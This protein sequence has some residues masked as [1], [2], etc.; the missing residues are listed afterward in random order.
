MTIETKS[1]I[2]FAKWFVRFGHDKPRNT[3]DGNMRLQKLLYF[4]QLI[5]L[6]KTDDVLFE[7]PIY[8][9]EN[10]SVVECVRQ[11]Y[12]NDCSGYVSDAYLSDLKLSSEQ[13]DTLKTAVEIFGGL[14][15]RELSNL[16]HFHK[17]WEIAYNYSIIGNRPIKIL[18]QISIEQLKELDLPAIR[19][20]LTA[21]NEQKNYNDSFEVI[22][23]YTFY[24]N[25][26]EIEINETLLSQLSEFVGDESSYVIYKDESKGIVIM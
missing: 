16:N 21:Y 5:H 1:A 6:A 18:S 17:S 2:E 12:K 26:N 11:R 25:P 9:F 15:A 20:M 8:A 7:D 19:E 4:A 10:G 23:G 22:N 24:Y 14:T 3:F 13:E